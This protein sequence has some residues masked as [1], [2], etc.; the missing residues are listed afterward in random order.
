[1]TPKMLLPVIAS[2]A[3]L[4]IYGC[5]KKS[6]S[7]TAE[8]AATPVQVVKAT[9]GSIDRTVSAEGVLYPIRQSS[10]T[11][12]ITAPVG[13]FLVNRG[14]HV[15]EGQILAELEKRDLIAAA[16]ESKALYAQT[17]SQYRTITQG[18]LPEDV[19]K[20]RSDVESAKQALEAAKK[21]YASRESLVKEGALAQRL[22]D[23]AKVSL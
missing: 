7:E 20:A 2:L 4:L 12:K 22:A 9:S 18:T 3:L 16:L 8:D 15:R 5:G 14:G 1:M 13:R 17:E 21:V 23:D 6:E 19:T 11:P 10:I